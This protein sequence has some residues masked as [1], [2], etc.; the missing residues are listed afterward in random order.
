[1]LLLWLVD[2]VEMVRREEK[3]VAEA[4]SGAV[5][6]MQTPAKEENRK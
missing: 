4:A 6:K 3:K 1:V 5:K 2:V